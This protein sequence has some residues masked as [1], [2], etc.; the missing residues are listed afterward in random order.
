VNDAADTHVTHV[1]LSTQMDDHV[2]ALRLMADRL[3]DACPAAAF[4]LRACARAI[5]DARDHIH[6]MGD[7]LSAVDPQVGASNDADD[8][9]ID[10]VLL[11][12]YIGYMARKASVR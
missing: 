3:T 12:A 9:P 8:D 5:Q 2:R 1:R 4:D 10:R 7:L 11:R 6:L